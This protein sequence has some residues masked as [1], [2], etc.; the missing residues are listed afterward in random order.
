MKSHIAEV[1]RIVSQMDN[2]ANWEIGELIS[3]GWEMLLYLY[4]PGENYRLAILGRPSNIKHVK[5][6]ARNMCLPVITSGRYSETCTEETK[7]KVKGCSNPADYEVFL[8]DYYA[9]TNNTFF[10][11]HQSCGFICEY[12]MQ[13]NEE[14]ADSKRE[15]RG[16]VSYPY[17]IVPVHVSG[18]Y[19]KYLPAKH[20]LKD[21]SPK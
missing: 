11:R 12:H 1:K 13:I 18:G 10:E 19:I 17:D 3:D 21:I 5:R 6:T 20:K 9:E 2:K 7:C 8:Y 15:P 4:P 14:K 16:F